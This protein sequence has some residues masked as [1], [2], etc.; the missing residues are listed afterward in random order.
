MKH[1]YMCILLKCRQ[2]HSKSE[3]FQILILKI[4]G[5]SHK[6]ILFQPPF[7]FV[8]VWLCHYLLPEI[9]LEYINYAVS[10]FNSKHNII[11]YLGYDEKD[12]GGRLERW[13]FTIMLIKVVLLKVLLFCTVLVALCALEPCST[14]SL[15]TQ[16][17][18]K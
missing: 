2:I 5:A 18:E 4:F 3:V 8:F 16:H 17:R 7:T 14:D 10:A 6:R 13:I 11:S 9:F 12:L 15:V 1:W